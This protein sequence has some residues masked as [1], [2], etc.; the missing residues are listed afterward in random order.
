MSPRSSAMRPMR[1]SLWVVIDSNY[2]GK[3]AP[4]TVELTG[5][6]PYNQD[7]WRVTI[8][9]VGL[10][11]QRRPSDDQLV[12]RQHSGRTHPA[13]GG[14]SGR[15]RTDPSAGQARR[16]P[17]AVRRAF[18][19]PEG[20][21]GPETGIDRPRPRSRALRQRPLGEPSRRTVGPPGSRP[22]PL[23]VLLRRRGFGER[24]EERRV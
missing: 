15:I 22:G 5:L 3:L 8:Y 12:V 20:F 2:I 19:S 23:V 6:P 10:H 14:Q 17:G 18:G 7:G 24:S 16:R 9:G 13:E 11:E 1:K 4:K 21:R